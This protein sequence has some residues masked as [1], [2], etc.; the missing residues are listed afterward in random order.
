MCVCEKGKE[1]GE[2]LHSKWQIMLVS[3]QCCL[4][5][6]AG[7]NL[8]K[9]ATVLDVWHWRVPVDSFKTV[10]PHF[11]KSGLHIAHLTFDESMSFISLPP[12]PFVCCLSYQLF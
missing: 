11:S 10:W 1:E 4:I 3:P 12:S 2:C 9:S 6:H 5:N 8:T 7:L